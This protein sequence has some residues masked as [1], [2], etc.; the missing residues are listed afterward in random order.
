M[1]QI[2]TSASVKLEPKPKRKSSVVRAPPAEDIDEQAINKLERNIIKE[3]FAE[4]ITE[5]IPV[6]IEH[7]EQMNS[8]RLDSLTK[9]FAM[10]VVSEP[11][12]L[13]AI[14]NSKL[15]KGPTTVPAPPPPT[16]P[17]AIVLL[18]PTT[19]GEDM[20]Q[21]MLLSTMTTGGKS[22]PLLSNKRR[23]GSAV[24]TNIGSSK[25]SA[26]GA[27]TATSNAAVAS[28]DDMEA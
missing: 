10:T 27:T 23:N 20:A 24:G 21:K 14:T 11:T 2:S 5:L 17:P 15:G 12:G 19:N 8:E 25:A 7:T 22:N 1:E 26:E 18:V 9:R 3:L 16:L 4:V 6:Y 28:S 13:L